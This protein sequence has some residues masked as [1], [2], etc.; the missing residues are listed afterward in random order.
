MVMKAHRIR[1]IQEIYEEVARLHHTTPEQVE[2]EI[3]KAIQTMYANSDE[4]KRKRLP[5][6]PS[7]KDI[8]TNEE[9][10]LHMAGKMK[11]DVLK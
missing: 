3:R 6:S 5:K 11:N 10:I 8:P 1:N 7:G 9:F 2:R 4:D